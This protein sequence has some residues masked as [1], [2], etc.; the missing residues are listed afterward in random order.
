[1]GCKCR[2]RRQWS[3][4]VGLFTMGIVV[5][6]CELQWNVAVA[7]AARQV[8][9]RLE[10]I[11]FS[12]SA[13][14]PAFVISV[15]PA[16]PCCRLDCGLRAWQTNFLV[17]HHSQCGSMGCLRSVIYLDVGVERAVSSMSTHRCMIN[18]V[19]MLPMC[20]HDVIAH[21]SPLPGRS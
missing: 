7:A 10:I 17:S 16:W 3:N 5:L 2:F 14:P 6:C 8:G 20:I 21:P 18:A 1:V 13:G 4:A 19:K 15:G 11:L 9:R 12:S